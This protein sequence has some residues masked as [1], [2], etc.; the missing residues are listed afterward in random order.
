MP[1]L[2]K[3][4]SKII[5]LSTRTIWNFLKKLRKRNIQHSFTKFKK[6]YKSKSSKLTQN[7][8]RRKLYTFFFANKTV[9]VKFTS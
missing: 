3:Q 8:I 2:Q 4:K 5:N 6:E 1:T 9:T 7:I